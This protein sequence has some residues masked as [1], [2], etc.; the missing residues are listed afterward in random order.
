MA[1][2]RYYYI[3]WDVQKKEHVMRDEKSKTPISVQTLKRLPT[4]LMFLKNLEP[5]A[6]K[7]I[8]ATVIAAHLGLNEVQVRKDLA[9]VSKHAGKPRTG[10]LVKELIQDIEGFLG[11]DN[12][13]EAVILGAGNL[14]CA[15]FSYRQFRDYGLQIVAAFDNDPVVCRTMIGGR[16]IFPTEKLVDLCERMKIRIGILT[17]PAEHAQ[18]ACNLLL[19]AG[20]LVI[21][22]FTPVNL[23]VPE[24][25]FVR[26]EDMGSSIA[27][28]TKSLS[29]RLQG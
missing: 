13:N 10:F 27:I 4:Y 9:S 26:N 18:T 12:S 6:K 21:W 25:I 23:S 5:S 20:I 29:D 14:G 11:Y 15:L 24:S 7:H 19:S 16:P 28:I 22:N 1:E 8:S 2:I 17:V 3:D